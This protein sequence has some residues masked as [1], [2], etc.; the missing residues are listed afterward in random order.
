MIISK[1]KRVK[2]KLRWFQILTSLYEIA[3]PHIR[4]LTEYEFQ[5]QTEQAVNLERV[6]QDNRVLRQLLDI[7]R[8]LPEPPEGQL[9]SIKNDFV[10]ALSNCININT[11]LI[12]YGL[13][14]ENCKEN[15]TQVY[16]L[17]ISL[18]LARDYAESTYRRLNL[19]LEQ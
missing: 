9:S 6:G 1:N 15:Q 7:I 11:G 4:A 19:S 13:L 16:N 5:V 2:E 8:N 17:I 10:T 14:D 12:N 3:V 18:A